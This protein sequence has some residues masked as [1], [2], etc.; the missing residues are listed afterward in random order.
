MYPI[1]VQS[2]IGKH[3]SPFK[4]FLSFC[5]YNANSVLESSSEYVRKRYSGR[6]GFETQ[7]RIGNMQLNHKNGCCS[8]NNFKRQS[9]AWVDKVVHL[10]PPYMNKQ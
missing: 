4:A 10:P 6:K 9:K 3:I 8:A 1:L 7:N 5:S 2:Y